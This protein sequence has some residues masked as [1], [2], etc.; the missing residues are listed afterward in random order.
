MD[1]E[2]REWHVDDLIHWRQGERPDPSDEE[3]AGMIQELSDEWI[4]D[5]DTSPNPQEMIEWSASKFK[6]DIN[7]FTF[8][9][10]SKCY[11]SKKIQVI[12]LDKLVKYSNSLKILL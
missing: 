7:S 11:A 4:P 10:L 12:Q 6:I 1:F 8:E 5:D 2:N 9:A 3:I